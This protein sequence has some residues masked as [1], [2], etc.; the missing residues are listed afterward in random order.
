[1][2]HDGATT[3]NGFVLC[4]HITPTPLPTALLNQEVVPVD[5]TLC[6]LHDPQVSI[7]GIQP[8]AT[9]LTLNNASHAYH[10]YGPVQM[11]LPLLVPTKTRPEQTVVPMTATPGS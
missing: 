5:E 7:P 2:S 11:E 9:T 1:M 8:Q 6:D 10:V 4:S 3:S